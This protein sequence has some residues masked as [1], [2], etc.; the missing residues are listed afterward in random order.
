M[1]SLAR[2][3]FWWPGL[4]A[5]IEAKVNS[6]VVCQKDHPTPQRATTH[7][8]EWPHHPW[9]RLHIDHAGPFLGHYFLILID[10]HSKWIEAVTVPSTSSQATIKVLQRLF[11]T[12]GIPTQVVWDNGPGFVSVEFKSFLQR[13]GIRQTLVPPYHLASKGLA[14]RAVQTVKSGIAKKWMAKLM[15][16]YTDFYSDTS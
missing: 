14:E 11:A 3:Y 10:T 9:S 16:D 5:A 13:N 1:K 6:C 4:D 2:S 12:H 15:R 7:P 8:W